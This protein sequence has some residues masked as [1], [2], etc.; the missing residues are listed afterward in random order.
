MSSAFISELEEVIAVM[1]GVF[2]QD[3]ILQRVVVWVR[4]WGDHG[5]GEAQHNCQSSQAQQLV[6]LVELSKSR[7]STPALW[8]CPQ[9]P[10][11]PMA[12]TRVIFLTEQAQVMLTATR[13]KR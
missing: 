6:D 10:M 7:Q 4:I 8:L 3:S 11:I 2:L 9:S 12:S 13:G 1:R 5:R